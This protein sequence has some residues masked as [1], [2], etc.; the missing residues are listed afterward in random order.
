MKYKRVYVM[1]AENI[2]TGKRKSFRSTVQGRVPVGWRCIGVAGYFDK[3]DF[4][5]KTESA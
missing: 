3:P 2:F 5:A 1:I 4:S